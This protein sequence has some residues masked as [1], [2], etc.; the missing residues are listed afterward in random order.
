MKL[1]DSADKLKSWDDYKLF[2][3]ERIKL[4]DGP[5]P[6]FISKKKFDFDI[7]GKK[8]TSYAVLGG[9]KAELSMK[10]LR[11]AGIQFEEGMLERNGKNL[12]ITNVDSKLIKGAEKTVKMLKLGY[13]VLLDGAES[14]ETESGADSAPANPQLEAD[15]NKLKGSL[16]PR[17]KPAISGGGA[18]ATQVA[19]LIKRST[20]A[21]KSG[22]F[23]E[24]LDN[25]KKIEELVDNNQKELVAKSQKIDK[26]VKVW[27]KTEEI[28]TKELR[29][30]Q[31]AI[32]DL[33]DPRGNAVVKGLETILTKLD[34]VDDEAKEA[35]DAAKR[36]DSKGFETARDDFRRKMDNI[37]KYV[38]KDEL[39][40]DADTNPAVKIQIRET[41][42]KSLN[43]LMSVV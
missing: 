26:A 42:T 3:K 17:I 39:I 29:K 8:F 37:L 24:A 43:Q 32:V 36:G 41:I 38:E 5:G 23:Q 31:K 10:K 22:N 4:A 33:K 9:P 34:K 30:L 12:Q 21:E 15:W 25:F 35:A 13:K 19:D 6:I 1:I 20:N 7:N 27:N 14:D 16:T 40:R 11:A 18:A 28:A 2:F